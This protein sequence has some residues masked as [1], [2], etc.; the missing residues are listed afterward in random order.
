MQLNQDYIRRVIELTNDSPFP[1]HMGFRLTEMDWDYARV[2]L[3]VKQCHMQPYQILHGG[4]ISTLIDT[5]TFWS[6]FPR[7]PAEDGLVNVDLKLNYLKAVV[8]GTLTA[9]GRCLRFGRSVSYAEAS[10]KSDK[11]ELIGHGTSTLMAV[12]GK[13]LPIEL[14]KFVGNAPDSAQ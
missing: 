12:P 8:G 9:E 10:I 4:V 6:V 7:I 3:P 14:E 11:G 1:S 5:A 2:T 13:G